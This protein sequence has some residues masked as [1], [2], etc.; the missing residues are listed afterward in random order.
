M[1]HPSESGRYYFADGSPAYEVQGA[2]GLVKPT[3]VHARKMGLLPSVT[4]VIAEAAKPG[5]ERWKVTQGILAALTLPRIE[6]ESLDDFAKRAMRDS[7]E[8]A[9]QAAANGTAIHAAIEGR[10]VIG[11]YSKFVLAAQA[12]VGNWMPEKQGWIQEKSFA[13]SLGFAGKVDDH[14]TDAVIDYKSTDKPL[15]TLEL[16]DEHAEQLSAYRE[17]L[18]IPKARCAIVYVSR[19]KPE[20]RLIEIPEEDLNRGWEMFNA[21]LSFWYARNGVKRA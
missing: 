11:V 1:T 18:G 9:K 21:L 4:T 12:Q 2:K 3:I 20:A 13:S 6:G 10:D 17:G 19:V 14:T 5:L 16:W 15:E 8:Q 7:Q